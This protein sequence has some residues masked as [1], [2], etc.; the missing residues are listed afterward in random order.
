MNG[1]MIA[2]VILSVICIVETIYILWIKN[3]KT[4]KINVEDTIKFFRNLW[5]SFVFYVIA[6]SIIGLFLGSVFL[7]RSIE[8]E[9][10]N[11]W[12]SIVLGLVA[13]IIGII[14]LFLSFYNVD[15]S[16]DLQ[17][18]NIQIM[19][20]LQKSIEKTI[21][22][23]INELSNKMQ[24]GFRDIRNDYRR[25]NVNKSIEVKKKESNWGELK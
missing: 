22:C 6:T 12:V 17:D 9:I 20:D 15:Q 4:K 24:K 10:I 19:S 7:Q 16:T 13:L 1:W 5:G 3:A 18:K 8:L 25:Q 14:S 11:N 23:K 2:V 21:D